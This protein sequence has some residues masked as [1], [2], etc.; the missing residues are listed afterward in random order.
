MNRRSSWS[1][2]WWRAVISSWESAGWVNNYRNMN[3]PVSVTQRHWQTLLTKRKDSLLAYL[4]LDEGSQQDKDW[5]PGPD[6]EVNEIP[7]SQ[8]AHLPQSHLFHLQA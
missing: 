6:N 2:M 1:A 4:A 5:D 3:K 7:E 8:A